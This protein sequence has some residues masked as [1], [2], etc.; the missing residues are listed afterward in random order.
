MPNF[1]IPKKGGYGMNEISIIRKENQNETTWSGGKTREL[2]IYPQD[3]K[4]ENRNFKFRISSATVE[5]EESQFTKLEG[6]FRIL[7]PLNG[8]LKIKYN[9]SAEKT[10]NAFEKDEFWGD[11]N[12]TSKGKV[13][14]FNLMMNKDLKGDLEYIEL[15]KNNTLNLISDQ[16]LFDFEFLYIYSGGVSIES[17]IFNEELQEGDL[18][19]L[20]DSMSNIKKEYIIKNNLY[21]KVDIIKVMVTLKA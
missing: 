9:D 12:T 3:S 5:L 10:L 15:K 2:F 13:I 6:I 11:C 14:D 17:E 1:Y 8:K 20:H 19:V 16:N 18:L 4:Y 21:E 7:M